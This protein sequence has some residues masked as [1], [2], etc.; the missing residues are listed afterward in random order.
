MEL[1]GN[2]LA[3]A[4]IDTIP[5]HNVLDIATGKPNRISDEQ[6]TDR[7]TGTGVWAIEFGTPSSLKTRCKATYKQPSADSH[8]STHVVGT[9][10]S[11]IQPVYVP[12]NCT[13][14]VDDAEDEWL[15]RTPF[16]YIHA[17]AILSCFKDPLHVIQSAYN[18]LSPGGILEFQD[19]QFPFDFADPQPPDDS[20]YVRWQKLILESGEKSGKPLTNAPRYEGWFKE[21]G[22]VDVHV[23]KFL[24]PTGPWHE[25]QRLKKL[26]GWQLMN[27]LE[28]V[29]AI[30]PRF[31]SRLGWEIEESRVL[32]AQVRDEFLKG[33]I[34]PYC[35][36]WCVWGRKPELKAN[37]VEDGAG[38]A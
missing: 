23:E 19:P 26:G 17:R 31:L 37:D 25:D 2:R 16:S 1:L 32:V 28:A 7:S 34:K 15:F 22:F 24:I 9:D 35:D 36:F 6:R 30:T 13:F 8:P 12:P 3:V 11:P 29:D 10:L 14:E 20:P 27:W 38:Y 21:A 5:L 4:P 18:A 33:K